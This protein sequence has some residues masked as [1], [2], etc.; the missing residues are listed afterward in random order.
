MRHIAVA[1]CILIGCIS[2][3]LAQSWSGIYI[4]GHL[5]GQQNSFN[6][7]WDDAPGINSR[8]FIRGPQ[9]IAIYETPS[10]I[11]IG[12]IADLDFGKISGQSSIGSLAIYAQGNTTA[13]LRGLLGYSGFYDGSIMPYLTAGLLAT[14][15]NFN[16]GMNGNVNGSEIK[17]GYAAGIGA[18]YSLAR[19]GWPNTSLYGEFLFENFPLGQYA[20]TPG[21]GLPVQETAKVLKIGA[22]YRF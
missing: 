18:M 17:F 15:Q 5:G 8:S 21:I 20:V 2:P 22:N 3:S 19:Y 13:S 10:H 14:K 4:G 16:L 6:I 12:L 1:I 7:Q 11:D 9:I